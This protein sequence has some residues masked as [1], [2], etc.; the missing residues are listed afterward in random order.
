MPGK[1]TTPRDVSG[2]LETAR[3]V[4]TVLS[5]KEFLS[6]SIGDYDGAKIFRRLTP[7]DQLYQ[8]FPA[9]I[10]GT[11]YD[12]VCG[13]APPI[14]LVVVCKDSAEVKALQDKIVR[15]IALGMLDNPHYH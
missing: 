8:E 4:V 5:D 7:D 10:D 15:E 12:Y 2:Y 11:P 1:T 13:S 14:K 9:R 3:S 6:T